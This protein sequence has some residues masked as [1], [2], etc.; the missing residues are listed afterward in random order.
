MKSLIAVLCSAVVTFTVTQNASAVI[1]AEAGDAGQ[2]I[3]TAQGTGPG[4]LSLTSIT[5]SLLSEKDVDLFAINITDFTAFSATTVNM[6]TGGLDTALFLFTS[7]G[8]P[9]YGNDD[10]AG[11]MSVGSTLPAGSSFGPTSNGLYYLAVCLSGS[12]PVNFANQLLFMMASNTAVRGP[13]PIAT[14]GLADWDTSLAFGGSQVFPA[15]YQINLTGAATAVPEPSTYVLCGLGVIALGIT[16]R[17]R[18]RA[19]RA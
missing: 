10:D 2:T 15:A 13:N 19:L 16:A 12:E 7:T 18:G 5:G 8:M 9:V 3:G 1:Y 11:G 17:R 14:G 6:L 4:S